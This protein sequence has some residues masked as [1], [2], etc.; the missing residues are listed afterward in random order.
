[1][2][3]SGVV[4]WNGFFYAIYFLSLSFIFGHVSQFQ[5]ISWRHKALVVLVANPEPSV[6]SKISES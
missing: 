6:I 2:N 4:G 5:S 3:V 1:M